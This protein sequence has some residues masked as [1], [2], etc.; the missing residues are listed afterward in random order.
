MFWVWAVPLADRAAAV[1]P[2][3][4]QLHRAGQPA[5]RRLRPVPVRTVR[6]PRARASKPSARC[7]STPRRRTARLPLRRQAHRRGARQRTS[8]SSALVMR[9]LALLGVYLIARYL[10]RLAR[11]CGVE[12]SLAVWAGLLNPLVLMHFVSGAHNDALMLGLVD[13]R[14]RARARRH[15]RSSVPSP[16]RSAARS[17]RPR[18]SRSAS[19]DSRGRCSAKARRT[20]DGASA[21]CRG[22]SSRSSALATFLVDE[23]CSPARLRLDRRARHPGHDPHLDVP[24]HGVR[25]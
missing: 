12:P 21:S 7:G 4:L 5:Q 1:Q 19:S 16:S 24:D 14:P 3:R 22:S 23:R 18:C 11:A 15:D 20:H 6:G 2:G 25:R 13:R 10:P 8:T 9:L 17:R